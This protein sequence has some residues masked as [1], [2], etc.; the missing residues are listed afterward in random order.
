MHM[1]MPARMPRESD[2]DSASARDGG[3]GEQERNVPC[4]PYSQERCIQLG[5]QEAMSVETDPR[6][7]PARRCAGLDAGKAPKKVEG[8]FGPLLEQLKYGKVIKKISEIREMTKEDI[9][10]K[11]GALALPRI[12][13]I[14]NESSGK[15]STLERI[16]GQPVLPV[17]NFPC[18]LCA[19]VLPSLSRTRCNHRQLDHIPRPPYLPYASLHLLPSLPSLC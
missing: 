11:F 5:F 17:L 19:D 8:E 1:H 7:S 4:A 13:V 16:A 18:F 14:G 2:S 9:S 12:L 6:T 15:S 10:K 3:D